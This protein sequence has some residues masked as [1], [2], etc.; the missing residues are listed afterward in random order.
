MSSL[1][2]LKKPNTNLRKN[3]FDLSEKNLFSMSAGMLVP[4]L[5]KE[6]NPGEKIEI[7]LN[8]LTRTMPLNTAAF[9]RNRQ[10]YHFFFVP[11]KQLWSGWDNFINGVDYKTSSL[12]ANAFQ[13]TKYKSVPA[14]ELNTVLMQ[15]LSNG[16]LF[17]TNSA[18]I[19]NQKKVHPAVFDEMGVEYY[20]GIS[21]LLDMLGYG[22][23]Y[24][25]KPGEVQDFQNTFTEIVQKYIIPALGNAQTLK[26]A[27]AKFTQNSFS[28]NPFRLLAYQK[29]YSDFYKRDDYEATNPLSFNI[30]DLDGT[31]KIDGKTLFNNEAGFKRLIEMLRLRYRWHPKDYFT[32]VVPTELVGMEGVMASFNTDMDGFFSTLNDDKNAVVIQSGTVN[33]GLPLTTKSIRSAFAVEKLL[34]LTRRAGGFDYISQISAHYGFEPPKGRGTD[35]EFIGGLTSNINISEVME[36]ATTQE[37]ATGRIFGKGIGSIDGQQSIQYDAKEHG[38]LMCITSIVPESDYSCEGLD[39]FN[40]KINRGDYFHPEFQ[41][42]GLQPVFGYELKNFW[43]APYQVLTANGNVEVNKNS[44]LGYNPRY[45]E[46]KTSYDK[47]HGEFRNGRTFSAWSSSMLL[48]YNQGVS[49]NSLKI[50]PKVLDRIFAIPFEGSEKS[51]NFLIASQF[52]VKCIRPMS[53]TGQNL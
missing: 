41:D 30:D 29:I 23:S 32:G 35:V 13:N 5:T 1:F 27:I 8:A 50:N 47:L 18:D 31:K 14:L 33:S 4:C 19:K 2:G 34:R 3:V 7:S 20:K 49:V 38:I 39:R 46:Y 44:V 25:P 52:V 16:Y 12:Q 42:L 28:V 17:N 9:V 15:L 45:A 21:R 24:H 10:Y 40:V 53:V 37:G 43:G 48:N 26:D 22:F 36:Q 6:M 51:D 11:F